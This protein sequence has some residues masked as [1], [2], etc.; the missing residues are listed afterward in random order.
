[1][2]LKTLKEKINGIKKTSKVTKAMESI[3]AIKMRHAQK[4]ALSGRYYAFQVFSILQ[5]LSR[6]VGS[7]IDKAFS[8]TSAVKGKNIILLI[9]PDKGL[10][11][12]MNNFLFKK[13][14]KIINKFNFNKENLSFVCVGKKG[15]KYIEKKDY[16]IEKYFENIG[17]KSP[18]EEVKRVSDYLEE[19]YREEEIS[20][21]IVIYTNFIN[22]T[23]QKPVFRVILPIVYKEMKL[24]MKAILPTKGKYSDSERIDIENDNIESY[25][26]EPNIETVI[27][28]LIPFILNI[29]VYYSLLESYASE[30]SA[31][32]IAMKN[33]TDKAGE[34]AEKTRKK[35]NKER[36]AQVTTEISEIVSGMEAMK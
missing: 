10:S 33:A 5:R 32:M 24:F 7:K 27:K 35:Y 34:L 18:Q 30:H 6:L 26:F 28:S 36:Q 25:L 21:I 11:G 29:L 4:K 17:E 16:K 15:Q 8:S 19:L 23:E 12:G 2:S 3:S 31:R 20:Q 9:S 22:T 1:M 13:V 14:D